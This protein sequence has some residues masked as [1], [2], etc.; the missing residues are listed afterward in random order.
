MPQST[1]SRLVESANRRFYRDGFRGVGIDQILADVGISKTAFYKHFESKDEL[2]L[3]VLRDQDNWL[4]TTFAELVRERGGDSP[5]N[6]LRA[7]FD[8]VE[9]VIESDQY[10]GCFF[11]N[12]AM[13]FPLPHDP[14]HVAAAR[15]KDAIERFVTEI[16]EKADAEDP[17]A[18]AK[19]LCLIMDGAY[20]MR[21]V[22]GDPATITYARRAAERAIRAYVRE[23]E[24]GS[25]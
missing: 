3:E 17:L 5:C 16:A 2:V 8:V 1:R 10:Q 15:N 19:E 4:R 9:Q 12:V 11:V 21:Q 18:L 20:V 6:Q 24:T 13:E 14:A 22:T 25:D 7:L 23:S